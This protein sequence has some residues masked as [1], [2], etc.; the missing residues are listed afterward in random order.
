MAVITPSSVPIGAT[1][2]AGTANM[3][4]ANMDGAPVAYGRVMLAAT[5]DHIE[6]GLTKI[7]SSQLTYG[8][9][10]STEL[11]GVVSGGRLTITG[12]DSVDIYYLAIGI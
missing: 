7:T 6:T 12:D 2:I 11:V 4:L 10:S 9:A 1:L 8:E 3:L 5:G